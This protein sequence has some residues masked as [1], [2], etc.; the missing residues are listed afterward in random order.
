M[1]IERIQAINSGHHVNQINHT[2][3]SKNLDK[4]FAAMRELR[5]EP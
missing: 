5:Y 2:G 4:E 3:I 1:R